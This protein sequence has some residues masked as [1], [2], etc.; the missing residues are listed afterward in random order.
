VVLFCEILE[1]I[2]FNPMSLWAEVYRVL[3]PGGRIV[4]T[5]PNVYWCRGRFWDLKRLFSRNGSGLPVR[6]ILRIPTYGHHWKEYSHRECVE[7]FNSLSKD[8]S[9]VRAEYVQDP[10]PIHDDA[11][12]HEKLERK[13]ENRLRFLR[14]GL[15]VEIE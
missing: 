11:T 14:W 12:K 6:E 15:D 3:A 2:T 7:Y 5:T 1:H 8:L 9:A 13:I 10:R 4:V